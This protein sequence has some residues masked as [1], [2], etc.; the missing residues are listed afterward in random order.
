MADEPGV[1]RGVARAA[2]RVNPLRSRDNSRLEC[3]MCEVLPVQVTTI[4]VCYL[5][6]PGE[7]ITPEGIPLLAEQ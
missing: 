1:F 5:K 7:R 3:I 6:Y 2:F 4:G